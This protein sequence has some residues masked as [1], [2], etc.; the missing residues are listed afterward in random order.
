MCPFFG[1]LSAR[2]PALTGMQELLINQSYHHVCSLRRLSI[3]GKCLNYQHLTLGAEIKP[4][5]QTRHTTD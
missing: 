1:G 4:E 3:Y 5:Q 2:W